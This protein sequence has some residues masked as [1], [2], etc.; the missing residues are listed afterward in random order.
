VT[1]VSGQVFPPLLVV[2]SAI[3]SLFVVVYARARA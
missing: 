3:P 1:V 2:L